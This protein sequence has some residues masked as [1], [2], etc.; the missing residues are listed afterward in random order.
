MKYKT[1]KRKQHKAERKTSELAKKVAKFAAP[2]CNAEGIELIYVEYVNMSG[3]RKLCIYIDKEGGVSIEDCALISK[4]L[5]NLLDINLDIEQSYSLEVSSPG[6]RRPIAKE[7]DFEKFAGNFVTLY[8][9]CSNAG[10]KKIKGII[11]GISEGIVSVIVSG[12]Q[13]RIPFETI[14][15]ARLNNFSKG[16]L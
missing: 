10:K 13:V 4:Q 11:E 2:I 5:G 3:N 12:E 1:K 7:A 15:G 14:Y 8:T 6:A 9:S 16:D